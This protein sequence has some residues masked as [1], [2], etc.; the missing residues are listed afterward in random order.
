MRGYLKNVVVF[1]WDEQNRS[2]NQLPKQIAKINII[3]CKMQMFAL[4]RHLSGFKY[5]PPI[6]QKRHSLGDLKKKQMFLSLNENSCLK[7]K[8]PPK[9]VSKKKVF[10]KKT[11]KKMEKIFFQKQKISTLLVTKLK[12]IGFHTV[13]HDSFEYSRFYFPGGVA[14]LQKNWS[15]F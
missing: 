15:P 6:F 11:S 13:S 12:H 5:S 9:K 10:I 14:L 3:A 4:F 1:C 2:V 8:N 7:K